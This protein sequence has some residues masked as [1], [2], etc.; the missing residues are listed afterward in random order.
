[1]LQHTENWGRICWEKLSDQ[2]INPIP[3]QST[4]RGSQY[5]STLVVKWCKWD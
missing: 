4:A 5:S 1:M 2:D 3:V